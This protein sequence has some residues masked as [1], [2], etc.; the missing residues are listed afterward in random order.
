MNRLFSILTICVCL[1]IGTVFSIDIINYYQIS[2][3]LLSIKDYTNQYISKTGQIDDEITN[4]LVNLYDVKINNSESDKKY[5]KKGEICF[6]VL[7]KDFNSVFENQNTK[8]VTM[9]CFALVS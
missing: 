1:I 9:K 6:Y 5:Y 2:N 7:S 4:N 3:Q 8:T